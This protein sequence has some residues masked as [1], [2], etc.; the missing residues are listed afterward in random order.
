MGWGLLW[1][2]IGVACGAA[3][4]RLWQ[5]LRLAFG[6]LTVDTPRWPIKGYLADRPRQRDTE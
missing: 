3:G 1:F 2:A 4:L 6:P 5:W